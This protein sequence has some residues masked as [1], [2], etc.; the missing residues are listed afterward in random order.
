[1]KTLKYILLFAGVLSFSACNSWLDEDPEYSINTNTAFA[2]KESAQ[3]ALQGCY[4]YMANDNG[5]GQAWQELMISASGFGWY[6]TNGND[7]DDYTSLRAIPASTLINM[8]WTG[9]YKL[10]AKQ[11]LLLLIWKKVHWMKV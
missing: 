4:G 2:T 7:Q 5:Y 3:M 11:M 6:Q 1:M 10:L 9:M 8:A